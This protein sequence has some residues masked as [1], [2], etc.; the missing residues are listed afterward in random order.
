MH[1]LII[2]LATSCWACYSI[3]EQTV[4]GHRVCDQHV[5]STRLRAI[6]L[7]HFPYGQLCHTKLTHA[8]TPISHATRPPLGDTFV[9]GMFYFRLS[10]HSMEFFALSKLIQLEV[11]VRQTV[12]G[13]V[14]ASSFARNKNETENDKLMYFGLQE[15]Y[16]GPC[17]DTVGA[18]HVAADL[19]DSIPGIDETMELQNVGESAPAAPE[20]VYEVL[21]PIE[22]GKEEFDWNAGLEDPI[23]IDDDASATRRSFGLLKEKWEQRLKELK[24]LYPNLGAGNPLQLPSATQW[25]SPTPA[26]PVTLNSLNELIERLR[27]D[28]EK[29]PAIEPIVGQAAP[30]IQ[31]GKSLEKIRP[32]KPV[33]PFEEVGL[34]T[35]A[36]VQPTKSIEKAGAPAIVKPDKKVDA[37]VKAWPIVQPINLI[38]EEESPLPKNVSHKATEQQLHDVEEIRD[39]INYAVDH[40]EY[41]IDQPEQ[42]VGAARPIVQPT[43]LIEDDKKPKPVNKPHT[44]TKEQLHDVKDIRDEISHAIK[45]HEYAHP[46]DEIRKIYRSEDHK[47]HHHHH[48]GNGSHHHKPKSNYSESIVGSQHIESDDHAPSVSLPVP[49]P[50][51]NGTLSEIDPQNDQI[52]DEMMARNVAAD[53]H[54]GIVAN[55]IE[56]HATDGAE[57]EE[58]FVNSDLREVLHIKAITED[59]QF[60][61]GHTV[62]AWK[63]IQRNARDKHALVGLTATGVILLVEKNGTYVVQA[64]VPMMTTPSAMTTYTR[65]N[66]TQQAIEGIV[67]V[68]TLSDLVFLRVNEA[69][70]EMRLYWMVPM[71]E[72][73]VSTIEYFAV[74]DAH[75]VVLV[76]SNVDRP[77]ANVYRFALDHRELYLRESITLAVVAHN[78]AYLAT[79]SEHFLAFPQKKSAVVYKYVNERFK[80]FVQLDAENIE[81]LSA[82]EMGGNAYLALG[83]TRPRILRYHLGE[84]IDQTILAPSW[85]IV[86]YFLPIPARTYRDD[87]IV[88]I[89]HRIAFSSHS[90]SVLEALIWNGEAFDPALSIPCIING[91]KSEHG[92][93]CMMDTDR[94]LGIQG[95]TVFQ[96]NHFITILSPRLEAPS[97]LFDL[98]FELVPS[99]YEYDEALIDLYAEVLVMLEARN[100][101]VVDAQQTYV[102]FETSRDE[103]IVIVDRTFDSISTNYA[104]W[105]GPIAPTTKVFYGKEPMHAENIT[106][107]MHMVDEKASITSEPPRAKRGESNTVQWLSLDVVNLFTDSI[108]NV[109][110]ADFVFLQNN[111]LELN[112][113]LELQQSLEFD[114]VQSREPN[115]SILPEPNPSEFR[116]AAT[117]KPEVA[118]IDR[119]DVPGDFSF[120][121]INGILWQ[122]L[123]NEIVLKNQPQNLPELI[124]EGVSVLNFFSQM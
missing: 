22:G 95:A 7:F 31:P 99:E 32:A 85:G 6:I 82:F 124:V 107:F 26:Q 88:L 5:R 80:F 27:V 83:G 89:Q 12:C 60:K 96:R 81:A 109:S 3:Q 77:S 42:D 45:N 90:I 78:A 14:V 113:T 50:L 97:G 104:E 122:D 65:W 94:E 9:L 61:L 51:M 1:F 118:V 15:L 101:E 56:S 119:L 67:I 105:N 72:H 93:G 91:K 79:G 44:V 49:Q 66:R 38:E 34:A 46:A 112:G 2:W 110:T 48:H 10:R 114:E 121:E 108:N 92:L 29:W 102:D 59:M 84:F 64:E 76:S 28:K 53:G 8:F 73:L 115:T 30:A 36:M 123:L 13:A 40:H 62:V 70:D 54:K 24:A 100:Q 18:K 35:P 120:E 75:L 4:S 111:S 19:Y 25:L 68:A 86:E 39:E 116:D 43:S 106:N 55:V 16:T 74:N 98:E 63:T 57:A 71:N 17:A 87:L 21:E 23:V 103:E 20:S 11:C 37:T 41:A 58:T 33:N 69:L 47:H 52:I 117:E